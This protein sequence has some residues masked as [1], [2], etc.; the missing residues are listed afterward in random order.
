FVVSLGL[1]GASD[2]AGFHM[3]SNSSWISSPA[4]RYHIGLDGLT[5]WL[6]ILSTFLTPLAIL[7]SWKYIEHRVKEFFAFLILLEFGLI[8]VFVSLDL[9]LFYVFWAVSLVPMYFLL[10]IWVLA[11]RN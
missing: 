10:G 7:V 1:V 11:R 3:E 9:F 4:I 6:V 2:S 8:G 5:L